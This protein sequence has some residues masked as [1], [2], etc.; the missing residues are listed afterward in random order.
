MIT[1]NLGYQSGSSGLKDSICLALT[2]V[3]LDTDG[4][5]A[6]IYVKSRII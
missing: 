5:R 6:Q 1:L 2:D 4:D 3:H